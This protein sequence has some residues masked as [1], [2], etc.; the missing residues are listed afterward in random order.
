MRRVHGLST[1]LRGKRSW[2]LEALRAALD[3]QDPRLPPLGMA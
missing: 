3:W 2:L 1:R